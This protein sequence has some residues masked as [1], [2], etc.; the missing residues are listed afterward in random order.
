MA[1]KEQDS[2]VARYIPGTGQQCVHTHVHRHDMRLVVHVAGENP[3]DSRSNANNNAARTIH[4][5]NPASDRFTIGS[6]YCEVPV[7]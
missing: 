7:S 3:K 4:V 1:I 5:V 2:L 6:D